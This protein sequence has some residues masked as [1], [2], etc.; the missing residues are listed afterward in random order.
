[1][2]TTPDPADA[3]R[4]AMRAVADRLDLVHRTTSAG[5]LQVVLKATT[6]FSTLSTLHDACR[7]AARHA[8]GITVVDLLIADGADVLFVVRVAARKRTREPDKPSEKAVASTL[9]KLDECWKTFQAS[10]A[11]TSGKIP[12]TDVA[13]GKEVLENV[14][15]KLEGVDGERPIQ[16]Y[17]VFAKKLAAT[18]PRPR[19]VLAIRISAGVPLRLGDLK[20]AL[21]KCWSDGAVTSRDALEGV[22]TVSL[23]TSTEGDAAAQFGAGSLLLVT[24][25]DPAATA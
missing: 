12:P 14:L 6:T 17:G 10:P 9:A 7:A 1:M 22:E 13:I 4:S 21:G 15:C 8:S 24:S 20:T 16:S 18:D 23:P 2:A 11:A 3:V 5:V 25:V 19:L